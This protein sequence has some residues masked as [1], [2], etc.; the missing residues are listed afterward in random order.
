[1]KLRRGF[2]LVELL[3]VMMLIGLLMA[4]LLPTI[5]KSMEAVRKV[6][7]QAQLEQIG[8]AMISYAAERGGPQTDQWPCT[9][10]EANGRKIDTMGSMWILC[11]F[12]YISTDHFICPSDEAEKNV[13]AFRGKADPN[14]PNDP[15]PLQDYKPTIS[16]SYQIPHAANPGKDRPNPTRFP[17]MADRSPFDPPPK[18]PL[19]KLISSLPNWSAKKS[20]QTIGA[21]MS[22]LKPELRKTVNSANHRGEGQMVLYRDGHADWRTSPLAGVEFDNIY[23]LQSGDT[24]EGRQVGVAPDESTL[25]TRANDSCLRTI[26][27]PPVAIPEVRCTDRRHGDDSEVTSFV[28]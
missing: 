9:D 19:G 12:N 13:T 3:T 27:G 23:T 7:C 26:A 24:E 5:S 6:K 28:G 2:T 1:M 20:E 15:F 21:F 8:K 16:Y 25:P 17:V 10:Y 22:N 14:N 4:M 11:R 18:Q